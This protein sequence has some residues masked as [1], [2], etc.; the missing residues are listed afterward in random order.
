MADILN[1]EII[2]K[3]KWDANAL[4]QRLIGRAV[5]IYEERENN[6]SSPVVRKLE[7]VVMLNVID[8]MWR[9]HLLEMDYLKEGIGL[10]AIGQRDPLVEYKREAFNLFK[11]LI[12]E[13][14]FDSVKLLFNTRIVTAEEQEAAKSKEIK[15]L[16]VSGPA[17][18]SAK[19]LK[20]KP[21]AAKKI[22]RN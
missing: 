1:R 11:E 17:E 20:Q 22:G 19:A 3:D 14:K 13:I 12:E 4:K 6:Y 8:N 10:R 7:K 9:G 15:N 21:I 18:T 5:K 16:V 2:I